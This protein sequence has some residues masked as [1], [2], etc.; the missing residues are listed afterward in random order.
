[1]RNLSIAKK[2]L[3]LGLGVTVLLGAMVLAVAYQSHSILNN[4]VNTLGLEMINNSANQVDQ[5]F[6]ELKTLTLGI[7]SGAAELLETGKAVTDDDLE[8]IMARYFKASAKDLN[9]LEMY[10]GLESSGKVGTGGDWVEKPDYDARKRPWY[11]QAVQEDKVVLT[12]PYVDANTGG[13]VIT[14]ATPVK[15]SSGKRLGV[16][17]ID[18]DL[19]VLSKMITSYTVFGKGYGF[20]LDREG[21]IVCHPKAEMV[22]KENIAK[23]SS[24][25]TPELAEAG[26]KMISGGSGF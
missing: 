11:I 5:Y 14:V 19:A 12:A 4:Q 8:P 20:L 25:I 1:M 10:V 2:L 17:G 7:A 23:P 26:R 18:V 15:D 22:M 24:V 21:N 6:S 3:V 9:V 13:L 16:A